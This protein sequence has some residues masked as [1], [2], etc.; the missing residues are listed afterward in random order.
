MIE[1]IL[2]ALFVLFC[3]AD[4]ILAAK[5]GIEAYQNNEHNKAAFYLT[6]LLMVVLLLIR[7]VAIG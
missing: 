4:I 7:Y 2:I 5:L 3:E 1:A 6:H